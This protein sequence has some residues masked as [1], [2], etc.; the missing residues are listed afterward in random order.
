MDHVEVTR[1]ACFMVCTGAL[2]CL[3]LMACER[4]GESAEEAELTVFAATSLRDAFTSL[5]EAWKAAHPGAVLTFHFAGTQQL[6]TQLEQ[7][8]SADVF[9]SAEQPHMDQLVKVGRAASPLLIARNE[10]V[11]VVATEAAQTIRGL[12]DL[13]RAARLVIGAAEVPIGRYTLQVLGNAASSFGA[14]FPS[15]IERK[16]V[17]RELNV[18]QV[19]NKVKLGEA[20]AG[21]VYR[22]DALSAPEL[23]VIAI[24]TELNVIAEYPI[25]QVTGAK[26]PKL[27]QAWIELVRSQQGQRALS[28]AG[29]QPLESAAESP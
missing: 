22:S 29:F 14:D 26:H 12:G 16:V 20:D 21:F 6:R 1:R 9:A 13:P 7:G 25:A 10:L 28:R 3:G 15:E 17:S 8:A 18:R 19:L 11:I 27:A 5:G 4:E 2:M 23:T 24:P